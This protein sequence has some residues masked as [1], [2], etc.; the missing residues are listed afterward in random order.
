MTA[1]RKYMSWLV[2]LGVTH[3]AALLAGY[4]SFSREP[5]VPPVAPADPPPAAKPVRNP[6]DPARPRD[7]KSWRNTDFQAELDLLSQAEMS[8]EEFVKARDKLL[9]AW[10]QRDLG[11]VMDFCYGPLASTN[12]IGYGECYDAIKK[13]IAAQALDVQQWLRDGRFGSNRQEVFSL[14]YSSLN[15]SGK[16]GLIIAELPGMTPYEYQ[17]SVQ[18]LCNHLD[19]TDMAALREQLV[20]HPPLDLYR[21]TVGS[22]YARRMME[23]N[24][25]NPAQ[26]FQQETD[27]DLLRQLGHAWASKQFGRDPDPAKLADFTTLPAP[28]RPGALKAVFDAADERGVAGVL[29]VFKELARLQCWQ[30]LAHE[31][32]AHAML[33]AADRGRDASRTL[34]EWVD[35]LDQPQPRSVL[36]VAVARGYLRKDESG[37]LAWLAA[38]PSGPE[39]DVSLA[40]ILA[41]YDSS[42]EFKAKMLEKVSDPALAAKLVAAHPELRPAAAE[43]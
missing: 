41:I 11:A 18:S 31:E 22:A 3:A 37:C 27:P 6:R 39:L 8:R 42:R 15:D 23:L 34:A 16:R 26:A 5:A 17:W 13:Q 14:W 40:E 24:W 9:K 10:L 33:V 30:D 12:P 28:A 7:G 25:Q 38:K 21:N 35:T 1:G 36:T 29:P 20:N 32:S 4:L 2:A 43:P 19:A